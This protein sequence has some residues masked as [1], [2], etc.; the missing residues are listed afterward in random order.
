MK[1][2][3]EDEQFYDLPQDPRSLRKLGVGLMV[4]A[5][6]IGIYIFWRFV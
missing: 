3:Y 6:V 1:N 2:P 4:W 5:A